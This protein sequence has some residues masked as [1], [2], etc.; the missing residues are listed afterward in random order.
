MMYTCC[1]WAPG[2]SQEHFLTA[3]AISRS[4]ITSFFQLAFV[5][6][7]QEPVPV[8]PL[9]VVNHCGCGAAPM[10]C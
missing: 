5:C 3:Y 6:Q 8:P 7:S 4:G 9:S 10:T 1:N 2:I